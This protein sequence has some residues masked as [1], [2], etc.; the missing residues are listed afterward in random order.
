MWFKKKTHKKIIN[1]LIV[2]IIT[3]RENGRQW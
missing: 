3:I 1:G 2:K